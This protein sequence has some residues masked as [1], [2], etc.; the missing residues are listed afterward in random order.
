MKSSMRTLLGALLLAT[1]VVTG[2]ASVPQDKPLRERLD[3]ATGATVTTLE[4]PMAFYRERP[5]LAANARDYIYIGPV[6]VNRSGELTY[7]LWATYASTIDR[8]RGSG[9]RVPARA[10]LMLDG[11]PL[12]LTAANRPAHRRQALGE[13]LYV[14]PIV[15]GNRVLYDL[16]RAQVVAI[17]SASD[18]G[19]VTEQEDGATAEFEAWRD[20][21]AELARFSR[22]LQVES[23]NRMASTVE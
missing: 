14:A 18:L 3:D 15:G 6:E 7:M 8:G 21:T 12:E 17:T 23:S 5:M 2:C 1:A 9:L 20:S 4:R 22:Y 16:T 19:L 13:W 11:T 10:Y